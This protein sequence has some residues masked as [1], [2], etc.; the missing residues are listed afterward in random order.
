VLPAADGFARKV[1]PLVRMGEREMAAY[2]VI[3]GIDYQV[4]EC[5]MAAGN[6]HLGFKEVLNALEDRS[7]GAKAA[8]LNG[9]FARGHERF[10]TEQDQ[11]ELGA[12]EECGAPTTTGGTCAFCSLR[13]RAAGEVPVELRASR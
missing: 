8:F 7:P 1:K 2:C 9:F 4:E 12:C 10:Q 6:R 13:N 11:V 5:P 3:R